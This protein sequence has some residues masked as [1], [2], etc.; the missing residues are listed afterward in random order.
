MSEKDKERLASVAAAAQVAA[1]PPMIMEEPTEEP[2]IRAPAEEVLIPPLS[3]RTA[4][5][6]LKGFVP[7]GDDHAKQD[8]YRSYLTSQ[9][10]H[11]SQPQPL[12]LE[13]SFDAINKELEDF[14]LSARIFKPMSLAMSSRFTSGSTSLAASDL[15]QA[16]PGLHLYDA[17]KA[18]AESAKPKVAEVE[19]QKP[20]TPREQAAANGMY[21]TMTRAVKEFYPVK[22]LCK[23]FGVADP[24]PEGEPAKIIRSDA[25]ATN[26][27]ESRPLPKNDASWENQFIHQETTQAPAITSTEGEERRPRT[28]GEVGMADDVNQGR[29][30][31]SYTKPS[32]DIFKA[33]FA[34]DDEDEDDD[35]DERGRC[36]G[37]D[38][39]GSNV[40]DTDHQ[41]HC[42]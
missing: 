41:W 22:L 32:I 15:K 11:T 42:G 10:L 29:D 37:Q 17:E 31:L 36:G 14:A 34:S 33:I 38:C 12:L 20:L 6:A 26:D 21:G 13:G 35:Q 40:D 30:T 23:R 27:L 7:Y 3:P 28:I 18:K 25:G 8:R 5:A 19:V 9:T 24:H 39:G 2:D 1:P 16:K 4:S